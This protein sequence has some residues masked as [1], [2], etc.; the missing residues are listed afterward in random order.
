MA[1]QTTSPRATTAPVSRR[2]AWASKKRQEQIVRV[3]ATALAV[4]GLLIVLFPLA[5]ML[6][7]SLKTRIEVLKAMQGVNNKARLRD[8]SSRVGFRA[9]ALAAW[10]LQNLGSFSG[11]LFLRAMTSS[12][13]SPIRRPFEGD[14]PHAAA[15]T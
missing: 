15:R 5:W 1:T 12:C 8:R 2:G 7:T 10:G 14:A 3:V 4:L 13:R 11:V 9:S 6:S